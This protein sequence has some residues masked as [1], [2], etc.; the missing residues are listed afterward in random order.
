MQRR[1]GRWT[2][3]VV[4]ALAMAAAGCQGEPPYDGLFDDEELVDGKADARAP[5]LSMPKAVIDWQDQHG[6][7]EHHVMWHVTRRWDVLDASGRDWATKKGWSRAALQEGQTKNG[8]EFLAMHRAMIQ[9]LK[10]QF[11]SS[12]KLLNG[13]STPP[14]DPRDARNPLPNGAT[15]EFS[16][17]M[18]DAISRLETDLK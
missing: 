3:G 6:W 11:P 2:A 10:K 5:S 1:M 17:E 4:V 8:L 12:A 18:L 9:L 16:D 15:T 14:V 13:W 7:G